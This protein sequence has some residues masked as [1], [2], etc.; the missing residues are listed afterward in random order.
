M[1]CCACHD[2][3]IKDGIVPI[4]NGFTQPEYAMCKVC[5]SK[6]LRTLPV[7]EMQ[8]NTDTIYKTFMEAV[9]RDLNTRRS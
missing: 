2:P 3:S 5:Y 7:I 8:D 6:L 1:R 4:T 9:D